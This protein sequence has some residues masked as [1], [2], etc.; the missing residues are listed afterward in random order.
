[1]RSN[2]EEFKSSFDRSITFFDYLKNVG[3]G[4]DGNV[5]LIHCSPRGDGNNAKTTC[6]VPECGRGP[7][8][9]YSGGIRGFSDF[10]WLALLEYDTCKYNTIRMLYPGRNLIF[11]DQ[12]L[13]N[14]A[15]N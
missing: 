7:R 14:S 15:L 12:I 13:A 10:P 8:R 5:T 4:F 1:M 6:L 11:P 2:F 9:E 3:C